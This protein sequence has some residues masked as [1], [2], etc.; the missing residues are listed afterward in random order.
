[1][2]ITSCSG[3]L[4]TG[5]R[6]NASAIRWVFP[7][8]L[9]PNHPAR[10]FRSIWDDLSVLDDTLLVLN[11]SRLVV[12]KQCQENVL[13]NLHSSHS[14]ISKTRQLACNLYYWPGMSLQIQQL[15]ENCAECQTL[16][17]SQHTLLGRCGTNAQ[18]V[19][20]FI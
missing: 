6:D 19:Y 2:L 17:P 12:P 8:T 20:G 9:P 7:A 13:R 11:D 1:M 18:R 5:A 4:K 10:H 15:I 14:G 3:G 16:R